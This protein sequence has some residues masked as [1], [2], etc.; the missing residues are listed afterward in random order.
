MH[1]LCGSSFF[2]ACC[3]HDV[4]SL[5]ASLMHFLCCSSSSWLVVIMMIKSSYFGDVNVIHILMVLF[6]V[7]RD[8]DVHPLLV[9][10]KHFLCYCFFL[11]QW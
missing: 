11:G 3:D 10:L 4:H 2:L 5:L 6:L 9:L 7:N 8:C 1:F